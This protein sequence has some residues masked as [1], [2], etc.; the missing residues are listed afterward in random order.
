MIAEVARREGAARRGTMRAAVLVDVGRFE[1]RDVPVAP[2]ADSAVRLRVAAVGLCGTDFH[3]FAGHANY[4]RD[5][6]GAVI[7]LAREPQILGHEIAGV[8]DEVGASVRDL[9]RGDLVV[10]DQGRSCVS[11]GR[12]PCEY[13]ATGDSHQCD[14]YREHGISGL[15]GGFAEY[16]DVP[17][18]NAVRVESDLE[19]AAVALVEPLGCVIHAC[20]VLM[21]APARYTIAGRGDSGVRT[22][23]VCGA[24]PAG[25]LFVQYLRRVLR[26][27]G[28]LLVA[29]PNARKRALAE[30]FG[31]ETIDPLAADLAA[32]VRERSGGR[33]VELVIEA[34]GSAAALAAMPA[35]IRRQATVLLYGHGHAGAD[36]SLLSPLQWMEPTLL[37]PTGASGGHEPDGRPS[38]YLRALRL[39][40]SGRVDVAPLITHRYDSL[41]AIP[42]AF[43]GVHR[44]PDYVKGVVL[45]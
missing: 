21:R 3:I 43:A 14:G 41:A 20:D 18:V 6:D 45:L 32:T 22:V 13:C 29:E 10:V 16:L 7:P 5:R 42:G 8:V 38:T 39:I 19:P 27:A 9:R 2:L 44:A 4:N 25:L 35:L 15:A 33:R 23:L 31:A 24:G 28:A 36:V 37:T 26:F 30:R 34:S 1:L 40:E 11:E 17:A 12:S